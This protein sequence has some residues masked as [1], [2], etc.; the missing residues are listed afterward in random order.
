MNRIGMETWR[1]A[2]MHFEFA[3]N[4][5]I[6]IDPKC[7]STDVRMD[8]IANELNSVDR[9]STLGRLARTDFYM[10]GLRNRRNHR[11][12]LGVIKINNLPTREP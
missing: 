1:K 4:V 9:D 2:H 12:F 6:H 11:R 5:V 10:V 8:R 7:S 3:P